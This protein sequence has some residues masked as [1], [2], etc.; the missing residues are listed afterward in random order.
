MQKKYNVIHVCEFLG[1]QSI[2][3]GL[4]LV[5]EGAVFHYIWLKYL[6]GT[7]SNIPTFYFEHFCLKLQ[8]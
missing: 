1:M 8:N 7:V 2:R 5:L 4:I 3:I 6:F